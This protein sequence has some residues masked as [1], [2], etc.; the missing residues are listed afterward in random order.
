MDKIT[1]S[2]YF[3]GMENTRQYPA[4]TILRD[5]A[6]R[7]LEENLLDDGC[8]VEING[9]NMTNHIDYVLQDND[10]IIVHP[11]ILSGG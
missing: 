11:M 6:Y 9:Q 7:F 5:F 10:R 2:V 3:D 4:G 8:F 1:V